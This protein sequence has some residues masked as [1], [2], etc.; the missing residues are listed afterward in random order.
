MMKEKIMNPPFTPPPLNCK[1]SVVLLKA[2][3]PSSGKGGRADRTG[4]SWWKALKRQA[5]SHALSLLARHGF[6]HTIWCHGFSHEN[7]N[8]LLST[9]MLPAREEIV[10]GAGCKSRTIMRPPRL[11]IE[12][13][14]APAGLT[15]CTIM[16]PL[17]KTAW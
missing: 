10:R 12:V 6:D 9:R 8:Y 13:E 3:A 16:V 1:I 17:K 15:P 14:E 11:V 7:K 4:Y 2:D 5:R